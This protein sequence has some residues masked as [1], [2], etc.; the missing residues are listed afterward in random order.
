MIDWI[1]AMIELHHAPLSSGACVCIEADGTVAWETPRK[2][3]VRGSH[4]STIHIRSV[5]GDGQGN[6]T[7]LYIDGNPSKWLQDITLLVPVISLPSSGMLFNA[8]APWWALSRLTLS[9]RRSGQGSTASLA[10][11]TTECSNFQAG[12]MFEPGC[13]R[14]SSNVSH[15]MVVRKQSRDSNFRQRLKSLVDCLLLQGR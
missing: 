15:A 12:P 13:V 6:A 1:A 2:M 14:A 5:G 3:L 4:D 7:H 11:I 8:S 9:V 10:S